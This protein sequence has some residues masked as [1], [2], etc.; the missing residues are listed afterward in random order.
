MIS[1]FIFLLF[2]LARLS[3]A[4]LAPTPTV[5]VKP[6]I[7]NPTIVRPTPTIIENPSIIIP[8]IIVFPSIIELPTPTITRPPSTRP[9]ITR[10]PTP[11]IE[12]PDSHLTCFKG[13][14]PK[15]YRFR[16]L[17]ALKANNWQ[18]NY[19]VD[20]CKVNPKNIQ[21]CVPST[22]QIIATSTDRPKL[23]PAQ[24]ITNDFICYF[25]RCGVIPH[26]P[27]SQVA[28]DQ[29]GRKEL[30]IVKDKAFKVCVPA[31]KLD[32]E[33]KPIIIYDPTQM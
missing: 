10:P 25:I 33:G 11:P 24:M 17:I 16:A 29:F 22:K 1:K 19:S 23:P 18:L 6:T 2:S 28:I 12:D 27:D 21:F 31:W 9:P 13:K 32:K 3:L 14:V 20:K 8:S 4:Q 7:V 30:K 5:I 15:K 26:V